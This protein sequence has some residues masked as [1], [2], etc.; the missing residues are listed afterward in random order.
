MKN[1]KLKTL[2][3]LSLFSL[4]A[5]ACNAQQSSHAQATEK[6]LS[7]NALRGRRFVPKGGVGL[8][9]D[10]LF[11][12]T[13]SDLNEIQLPD[14]TRWSA[15]AHIQT[16]CVYKGKVI[17]GDIPSDFDYAES[18]LILFQPDRIYFIELSRMDGGFYDRRTK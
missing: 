5:L 2:T 13:K 9:A 18:I 7:I 17:E 14:G 6:N 3:L 16:V 12:F 8:I 10:G 4:M 11:I 15:V 1:I